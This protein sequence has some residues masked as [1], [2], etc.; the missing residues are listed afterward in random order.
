MNFLEG[1]FER[2]TTLLSLNKEGRIISEIVLVIFGTHRL[3]KSFILETRISK[4]LIFIQGIWVFNLYGAIGF[5]M[6]G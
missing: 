5:A 1:I 3:I 4:F 6:V 2:M